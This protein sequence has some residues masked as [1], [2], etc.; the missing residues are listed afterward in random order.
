MTKTK[1]YQKPIYLLVALALVLSLA[2]VAVPAVRPVKADPGPGAYVITANVDDKTIHTVDT[3]TNTVYGPFLA[4]QL[5]DGE[6]MGVAVTPDN[7]M[8][9]ICNFNE[10][11][12]YFVDVSNPKSP[13]VLGS[14]DLL[15]VLRPQ[16]IAITPDG[17]FA[18]ITDGGATDATKVVSV[19]V[20]TMLVEDTETVPG[21]R[22]A[23]SVA[24][25][26][27]GTVIVAGIESDTLDTFT[28]DGSGHLTPG[29]SYTS[30]LNGPINV[31]VAPDGVTVI[32]CNY[33]NDTVSVYEVT[34]PGTLI[35]K[36]TVSGLPWRQQSVAFN[37]A[38][39]KAYVL[40]LLSPADKI[41]VL[42]ITGPGAVS[43]N[44]A[45][46][47]T[48]FGARITYYSVDY[49]VV[50][51][52]T[53]YVGGNPGVNQLAVVRLSDYGVISANVGNYPTGVA[54]IYTPAGPPPNVKYLHAEGGWMNI[55][56]PVGTQWHELWPFFCKRYHLSSWNDTSGD[57]VLSRCDRIDMYQKPA[58]EVKWY[59]VEE[60][61][62]TLNVT[63][64]DVGERMYIEL[65]GGYN[66]SV[67]SN[68]LGTQW[69]EIHPNFCGQYLLSNWKPGLATELGWCVLIE[70]T[71]KGN[72]EKT[73]WHVEDVAIDIIVT[74][75]PPPVGG[76][77]YPVSKSSLLAPWIALAVALAGG[78]G[79]FV[80]RRRKTGS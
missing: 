17:N 39:D 4:G 67:L 46:A 45:G 51:G 29:S 14:V 2:V 16:D 60:V 13:S 52:T 3:A 49:M 48:L 34:S 78:A 24:I 50:V 30:G 6:L 28:I 53:A 23:Q 72:Q 36:G 69:H 75:E 68:P 59:H 43:L 9:L 42:D 27:N 41:S 20:Q 25:A 47:A 54:S 79:W 5:G 26:P 15:G 74:M 18:L 55:T 33:W 76:E 61:T 38:G 19:N 12:V 66:A 56:D 11:A 10:W 71:D 65:E 31:G 21:G 1:W 70:L 58:G 80:L 64:V 77:A 22:K 57:G 62:I 37:Q 32:V 73:W 7:H 63:L 8:A 35:Y 44:T 40:S